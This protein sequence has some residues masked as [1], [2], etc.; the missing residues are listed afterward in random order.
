VVVL[1]AS[2]N[3]VEEFLGRLESQ[4]Y[5]ADRLELPQLHQLLTHPIEGHGLWLYPDPSGSPPTC[6]AAWWQDSRLYQVNISAFP[7]PLTAPHFCP[8]N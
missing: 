4:G 7:P 2:R 8:S 5:L 3:L 6:L 1:I